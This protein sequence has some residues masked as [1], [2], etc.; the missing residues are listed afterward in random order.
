MTLRT[1]LNGLTVLDFTQ[2]GA[3]PTCTSLLGDMGARV[4]KVESPTG[5]LGRGLGPAWI[6][7]DSALY[8]S[9]NRNK[10]G[11]CLDLKSADGKEAARRLAAAADII[12][13]SMRPGV[14]NRLGLGYEYLRANNP[15]LIYCSISAYGQTGPYAERAG[16]DGIL[17][18]DSGLMSLIGSPGSGP[19]KVQSPVVDI[20]TGYI[21]CTGILAQLA[22]RNKDGRGGY[23]DVNLLNSALALQQPSL[24]SYLADGVL[25]KPIGSAAPYSAP[26]EA[27]ETA[28]GWIMVAAYS[29]NRW[30]KL[31]EVLERHDLIAD[32]RFATS[33]K[34][35]ANR[36]AMRQVLTERFTTHPTE[37]WLRL[38]EAVDVLCA[39]VATYADVERHPQVIANA[40]IATMAHPIHG[41]IRVPGFPI[42][43]ADENSTPHAPGPGLGEHT[44]E[45]LAESE[46]TDSEIAALL[47]S[48]AALS[49]G[50]PQ[51][52]TKTMSPTA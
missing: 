22:Q 15:G 34:R 46:F 9:F 45:I 23:L 3:G 12:V 47:S 33:T 25:P 14:M 1:A 26:N 32:E 27:F 13:E 4:I 30:E 40:M 36:G 17:Q 52:S 5:E 21:A 35:V 7:D 43:S 48:G 49:A 11:I 16:V 38:L 31:C 42:N 29:G 10:R 41:A 2:I 50:R 8:Y 19:G 44:L 20:A 39:R 37:H 28:D 24:A 6:G 18:A 51:E